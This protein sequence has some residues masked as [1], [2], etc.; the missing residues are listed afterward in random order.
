L[1]KFSRRY[2]HDLYEICNNISSRFLVDNLKLQKTVKYLY[3]TL[4]ICY[5]RIKSEKIAEGLKLHAL[6]F[7]LLPY[8]AMGTIIIL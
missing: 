7:T 6:F 3:E 2:R 5:R 4:E 8:R 1:R